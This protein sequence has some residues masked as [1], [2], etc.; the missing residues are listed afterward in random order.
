MATAALL[1]AWAL[2]AFSLTI[3][4]PQTHTGAGGGNVFSGLPG[5]IGTGGVNAGGSL[6]NQDF[7][8]TVRSYGNAPG[9]TVGRDVS[10][11]ALDGMA[12]PELGAIAGPRAEFQPTPEPQGTPQNPRRLLSPVE[13]T[14]RPGP[15]GG[16]SPVEVLEDTV[17]D[18]RRAQA[19]PGAAETPAAVAGTL[20]RL[21]DAMLRRPPAWEPSAKA[22]AEGV[23][24]ETVAR[25]AQLRQTVRLANSASGHDAPGLYRSA[26]ESAVESLSAPAAAA[27]TAAAKAAASSKARWALPALAAAGL[28]AAR[29]GSA[30]EVRRALGALE[31]WQGLL[32]VPGSPLISNLS[33]LQSFV[34]S[35]LASPP[36]ARLAP[37]SGGGVRPPASTTPKA[38]IWFARGRGSAWTAVLPP[39]AVARVPKNYSWALEPAGRGGEL[40]GA[41]GLDIAAAFRA[42]PTAVN[43]ARLIYGD[44]RSRGAGRVSSFYHSGRYLLKAVVAR[45]RV[46]IGRMT[47][48]A[49]DGA[50]SRR[51]RDEA[52]AAGEEAWGALGGTRGM[53]LAQARQAL[54]RGRVL[55]ARYESLTGDSGGRL[56]LGDAERRLESAARAEGAGE[57]DALSARALAQL[58]AGSGAGGFYWISEMSRRLRDPG[59]ARSAGVP[60]VPRADVLARLLEDVRRGASSAAELAG[61]VAELDYD[62]R[63]YQ[64]VARVGGLVAQVSGVALRDGRVL[65]LTVLRDPEA[66]HLAFARAEIGS[67]PGLSPASVRYLLRPDAS[68]G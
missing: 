33:R 48:R 43:G 34:Q 11:Q 14:S 31:S 38:K 45:P 62:P 40:P 16:V 47:R 54:R 41:A 18:V 7:S 52:I 57:F 15:S 20:D 26:I 6:G 3:E 46:A 59:A 8:G 68:G 19:S 23:A 10:F 12:A 29:A 50:Q 13:S 24:G 4:T 28:D 53:T 25:E 1:L 44:L 55:A 21:F 39:A 36:T 49:P 2:P 61:T 66:G 37:Q 64:E 9:V 35:Q 42:K 58:D 27:F 32:S 5:G 30:G 56:A 17:R 51:L 67:G 65:W 22:G 60:V 63:R